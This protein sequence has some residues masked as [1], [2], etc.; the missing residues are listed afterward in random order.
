M[1]KSFRYLWESGLPAIVAAAPWASESEAANARNQLHSHHQR[2]FNEPPALGT[3]PPV[4]STNLA[5][6]SADLVRRARN[7]SQVKMLFLTI[8]E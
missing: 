2:K 3:S 4:N 8:I 6:L 1:W 7:N 5:R